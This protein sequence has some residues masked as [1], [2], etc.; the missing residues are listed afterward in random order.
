MAVFQVVIQGPR[1]LHLGTP[2][3]VDL[4]IQ[5]AGEGREN[6][7][8]YRDI[9]CAVWRGRTSSLPIFHWSEFSHMTI[10]L[11]KGGWEMCAQLLVRYYDGK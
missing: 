3:T 7:E 2:P 9:L 6:V 10:P 1:L 8:N 11:S 4:C 5:S